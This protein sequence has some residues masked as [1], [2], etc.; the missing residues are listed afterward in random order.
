MKNTSMLLLASS[1]IFQEAY[2]IDALPALGGTNNVSTSTTSCYL[3]IRGGF[4]WCSAKWNY[5][6]P[7][8][9][10]EIYSQATEKG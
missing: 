5:E 9:N 7:I 2:T 3:C 10:G 6:E 4:M 8:A 1:Y